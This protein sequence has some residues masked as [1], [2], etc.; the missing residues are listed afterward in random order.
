M[1]QVMKSIYEFYNDNAHH[2]TTKG[3]GHV[4]EKEVLNEISEAEKAHRHVVALQNERI[5][6]LERRL[7]NE[8]LVQAKEGEDVDKTSA[9]EVGASAKVLEHERTIAELQRVLSERESLART[10][11]RRLPRELEEKWRQRSCD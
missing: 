3:G 9:E 2:G 4:D 7:Q 6:E 1:K 10:T 5:V 11:L 8:K